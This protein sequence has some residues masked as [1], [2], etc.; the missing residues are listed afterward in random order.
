M[1]EAVECVA[2]ADVFIASEDEFS[3]AAVALSKNVRILT[4]QWASDVDEDMVLLNPAA[5][6]A[7]LP[8]EKRSQLKTVFRDWLECSHGM[9]TALQ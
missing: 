4:D 6:V 9:V 5:A 1:A 3:H 2:S 7:G 8:T